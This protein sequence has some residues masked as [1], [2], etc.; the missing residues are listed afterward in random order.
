VQSIGQTRKLRSAS[1]S[2]AVFIAECCWIYSGDYTL[3]NYLHGVASF[4]GLFYDID[5]ISGLCRDKWKSE[6]WIMNTKCAT[7]TD[8]IQAFSSRPKKTTKT[9]SQNSLCITWHLDYKHRELPQHQHLQLES[10]LRN[11]QPLKCLRNSKNRT[12]PL[13]QLRINRQYWQIHTT[14]EC[15]IYIENT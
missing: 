4:C 12:F 1:P 6:W 5:S 10:L 14:L 8:N 11:Q 3:F 13:T 15:R 2:T 9:V 7:N